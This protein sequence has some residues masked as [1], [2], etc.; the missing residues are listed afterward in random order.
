MTYQTWSTDL[1]MAKERQR[2]QDWKQTNQVALMEG[3]QN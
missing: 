2:I 3:T 1:E